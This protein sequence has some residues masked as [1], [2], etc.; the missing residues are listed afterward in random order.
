MFLD[1]FLLLKNSGIPVTLKEF[2]DLLEV[3]KRGGIQ[4]NVDEFY[5]ISRITLVKHEKHMDIFDQC[6][7]AYFKGLE[8]I[9]DDDVF[10]IPKEWL[11]KNGERLFSAEEMEKLKSMGGLEKLLERIKELMKEQKERHQ[12]GSK[13]IGTGG[14]SPFGAFGYNPEGIRIG[15]DKN[16]HNRAIKVWDKRNFKNLDEGM[17]L[18]TRNI[19]MALKKLR[20]IT[21]EG[22]DVELDL[23]KTIRR[24]SENA[25]MLELN[26]TPKKKNNI[27][28]LLLID[29]GG[30]MDEHIDLC[31]QLFTAARYEFK[32]L[33]YFYF[34]NC[35]YE[36]LWK[37][38]S[39]RH[40]N[41]ISTYDVINKYNADYKLI[42][43]GDASMSPYELMYRHGSVEHYNHEAGIVWMER[44]KEQFPDLVWLNP[45]PENEWVYTQ[46][47]GMIKDFCENHMYPL[48]IQGITDSIKELV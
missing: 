4:K 7:G 10:N 2:L 24:T 14:T 26:M 6:F 39:R 17:E 23:E 28:I 13:W 47:V 36:K 42:F 32:N 18:D 40:E 12:G 9:T 45:I 30:S 8:T 29:V 3:L 43:I 38:N 37:D 20:T 15:Q 46:S 19:K 21:R 27:K 44:L 33:E 1:F 16:R 11:K 35:V 5:Y 25:G 31:S 41:W 48:T 34:H 22:N